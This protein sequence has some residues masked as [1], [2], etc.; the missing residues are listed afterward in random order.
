[1]AQKVQN[2]LLGRFVG[3]PDEPGRADHDIP[4]DVTVG[5]E[6]CGRDDVLR[7]AEDASVL[8]HH[9]DPLDVAA[10]ARHRG[11]LDH[12]ADVA[13]QLFE[14]E[15]LAVGPDLGDLA[16]GLDEDGGLGV[17]SSDDGPPGGVIPPPGA[18]RRG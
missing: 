18:W 10:L 8:V 6:G 7:Q 16:A 9:H 15:G 17:E 13:L 2:G 14:A 12:P 3:L 5:A 1:M 11:D 4:D